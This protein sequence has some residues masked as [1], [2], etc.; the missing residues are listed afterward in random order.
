MSEG[1]EGEKPNKNPTAFLLHED[2]RLIDSKAAK[3]LA[4]KLDGK[5]A[6]DS[7]SK[8]WLRWD[9]SRWK[10]T[11]DTDKTISLVA[12]FVD[13]GCGA[14]GYQQR[15]LNAIVRQMQ[16]T[17]VLKRPPKPKNV[18]PFKNGLLDISTGELKPATPER[19]TDW[20][21]PHDYDETAECANI[22][23][24][25]LNAV[26]K[27]QDTFNLLRA[28]LAALVRGLPLQCILMLIG[29]GGS[30]KGVFQRLAVET[31]GEA[32]TATST[33]SNLENN[34]F[35]TAKHHGKSLALINEAGRFGGQLNML[36]AMTGRDHIPLEIKH[37][38]QNGSFVYGGLFLLATNDDI[39]S[40]DS[41]IER[42]RVAV[43]FSKIVS[44]DER[45]DWQ[46]RG[47]EE[48]ILHTEIPGLI[49]WLLQM[50]VHDIHQAFEKLP[51]RVVEENLLGMRAGSS[52]ADWMITECFLDPEVENQMGQFKA[53]EESSDYLYPA[54]RIWCEQNGRRHVASNRFKSELFEVALKLDHQLIDK[55]DSTTRRTIIYGI[56]LNSAKSLFPHVPSVPSTASNS[57]ASEGIEGTTRNKVSADNSDWL[58]DY[59]R[60]ASNL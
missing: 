48:S 54:Y 8:S 41:G 38:Q 40:S 9:G 57:K 11:Q 29:R 1:T 56:C 12:E 3:V 31:I 7:E 24:W 42:R 34:R 2:S 16:L 20:I 44:M 22:K 17:G 5:L 27:D 25:L 32:N 26:D 36:K 18:V 23:S 21:L 6:F 14:K 19:S 50:P 55:Q 52:V 4:K 53:G 60:T 37:Q 51:E 45:R 43:R 30:G 13:E 47:G 35:E 39:A 28:W 58:A 59:D 46:K 33:L 10:V 15:Y 49:R